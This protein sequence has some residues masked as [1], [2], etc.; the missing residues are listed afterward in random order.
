MFPDVVQPVALT[1]AQEGPGGVILTC[2]QATILLLQSKAQLL[3]KVDHSKHV[4]NHPW[5]LYNKIEKRHC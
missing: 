4:P 1:V 2:G 3:N 5:L